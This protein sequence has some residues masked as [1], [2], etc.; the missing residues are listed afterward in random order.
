MCVFAPNLAIWPITLLDGDDE[1]DQIDQAALFNPWSVIED[2]RGRE[3]ADGPADVPLQQ[4]EP[5]PTL[6]NKFSKK[7][8]ATRVFLQKFVHNP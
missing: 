4:G 7:L 3:A 5:D 6:W 8:W 2:R 1:E